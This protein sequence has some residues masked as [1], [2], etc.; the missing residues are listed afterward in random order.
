M[1]RDTANGA[2]REP[3]RADTEG[4]PVRLVAAVRRYELTGEDSREHLERELRRSAR[5]Q[6]GRPGD[7]GQVTLRSLD[8]PRSY[9]HVSCWGSSATL[10]AALHD[11]GARA[12]QGRL[13]ALATVEPAQA[14]GVGLL[15]TP[16]TLPDTAHAVLVEASVDGDPARFERDF[17][18]LAGP[19]MHD[20]G[21]GGVLLLRSTT[22][23]RAYLGLMWWHAAQPCAAAL[24]S[25]RFDDGRRRLE[26]LTT[27]LTVERATPPPP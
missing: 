10:L 3:R 27:R 14:V 17:G 6:E 26:R 15:G 20:I 22:D 18:A 21:F 25:T 2:S 1:A 24:S 9:L 16:A 23:P 13:G 11:G 7:R 4:E 5:R 19:F 12:E 8:R